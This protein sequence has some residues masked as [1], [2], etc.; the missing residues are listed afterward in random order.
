VTNSY[1]AKAENVAALVGR[2][3]GGEEST[4]TV[5]DVTIKKILQ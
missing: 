2:N 1:G 4:G 3:L 5:T